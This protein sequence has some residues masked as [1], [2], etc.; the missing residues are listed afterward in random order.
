MSPNLR[1]D[2][3][4]FS[5]DGGQSFV[6]LTP[7]TPAY[8]PAGHNYRYSVV[9]QGQPLQ[10]RVTAG[11]TNDNYGQLQVKVSDSP[12]AIAPD[13]FS[14]LA[15]NPDGAFTGRLKD[16]PQGALARRSAALRR[17]PAAP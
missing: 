10:I 2:L 5:L 13:N 9:G 7:D 8:D 3:L 16:G 6:E 1:T 14:T 17:R 11:S 4:R 12:R 15:T